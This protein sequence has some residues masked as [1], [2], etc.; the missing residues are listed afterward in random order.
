MAWLGYGT[1]SQRRRP[2]P[3]QRHRSAPRRR[4]LLV[5]DNE[6]NR[7]VARASCYPAATTSSGLPAENGRIAVDKMSDAEQY[8]DLILM[9][10]LM[11]VMDGLKN[12]RAIRQLPNGTRYRSSP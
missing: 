11:P 12:A 1:P 6:I 2:K 3:R 7:G 9:D 4:I 5:E 8:Y 10:V